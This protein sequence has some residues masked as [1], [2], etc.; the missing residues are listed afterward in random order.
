MIT[1]LHPTTSL[2]RMLCLPQL[3]SESEVTQSCLT[4]HHPMDWSPPGS[5]VH[6]IFQAIVLEWVPQSE[7]CTQMMS[8]HRCQLGSHVASARVC[9]TNE[10]F[11]LCYFLHNKSFLNQTCHIRPQESKMQGYCGTYYYISS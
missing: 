10:C 1:E 4:L 9:A 8:P 3:E 11:A 7:N 2:P 6:G 5:S